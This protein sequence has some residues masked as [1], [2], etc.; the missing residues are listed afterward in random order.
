[1]FTLLAPKN[2]SEAMCTGT[3][4]SML[5]LTC[6]DLSNRTETTTSHTSQI[7]KTTTT[8]AMFA[9][10][11]QTS[12]SVHAHTPIGCGHCNSWSVSG[13]SH[14]DNSHKMESK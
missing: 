5:N 8:A 14:C 4:Q 9:A 13:K 3:V 10:I 7:F 2:Y 1:M 6:A 11:T 12:L